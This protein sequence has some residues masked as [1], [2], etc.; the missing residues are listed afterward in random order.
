MSK[1]I[2]A[3]SGGLARI[4]QRPIPA[5]TPTEKRRGRLLPAASRKRLSTCPSPSWAER[6]GV[7]ESTIIRFSQAAGFSG[8]Q[9][10]KLNLAAGAGRP[11]QFSQ[12][13]QHLEAEDSMEALH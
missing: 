10:L 2:T 11:E 13:A 3:S 5:C 7:G 9:D 8:Y 1:E 4:R 6:C 12:P